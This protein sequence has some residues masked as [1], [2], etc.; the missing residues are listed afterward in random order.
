MKQKY[1]H[2]MTSGKD[3]WNRKC[4]SCRRKPERDSADMTLSGKL[5][6]EYVTDL[7]T[8]GLKAKEGRSESHFYTLLVGYELYLL[9]LRSESGF[10][11]RLLAAVLQHDSANFT[12]SNGATVP[13]KPKVIIHHSVAV[14]L[15]AQN[16][17]VPQ[18][19]STLAFLPSSGL[20]PWFLARHRF[21]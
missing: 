16:L 11:R 1:C 5:F 9:P 15:Q 19:I 20:T 3:C 10:W 14:S 18:I 4:S 2:R 17:P 13:S 7:S 21:F 6:H 8:C 12:A